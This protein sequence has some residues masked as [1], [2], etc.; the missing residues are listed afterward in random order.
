MNYRLRRE[1]EALERV[2]RRSDAESRARQQLTASVFGGDDQDRS[3]SLEIAVQKLKGVGKQGEISFEAIV[4]DEKG[5]IED[6]RGD[7]ILQQSSE[8]RRVLKNEV[9]FN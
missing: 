2:F 5:Q 3:R 7:M 1:I 4:V 6:D 9:L 8:A